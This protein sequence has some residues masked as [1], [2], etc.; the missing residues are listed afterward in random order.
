VLLML[1]DN[2]ERLERFVA[3]LCAL[4]P[5]LPLRVWSNAHA[6]IHEAGRLL[7]SAVLVSLDHDLDAEPGGSDPGD[8][9]L[10]AQ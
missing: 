2:R 6:M 3:V 7:S 10:V 1:E 9:Y 5:E 8:G 4:D